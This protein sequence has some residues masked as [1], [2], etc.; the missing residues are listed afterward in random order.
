MTIIIKK[1]D[2]RE[3]VEKKLSQLSNAR[4]RRRP[5]GFDAKKYLGKGIFGMADGLEFQRKVRNEWGR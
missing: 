5:L 3:Q 4:V 2:T 1:T